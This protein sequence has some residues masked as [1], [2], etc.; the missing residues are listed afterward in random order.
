MKQSRFFAGLC[1]AVFLSV[2]ANSATLLPNGKQTFV[3]A[4][5]KPLAGGTVTLYVPGTTTLKNSYRE[6]G[7]TTLNTNPIVLDAAGRA[8]IYG[9]GT[10]R[11]VV[12]DS[13]GNLIWDQL[14]SDTS[15]AGATSWGGTST[16][17]ASAQVVTAPNFT[18]V[19]GQTIAFIAGFTNP[20]PMTVNA[21]GAPI[22]VL[23]D[24]PAGPAT[25]QGGEVVAGNVVSI[26]YSAAGGT[27]HTSIP[28]NAV[29][30]GAV[31]E[32]AGAAPPP[33]WLFAAGQCVSRTTYARLFVVIG[34]LYGACDGSTT[35]AV[36]DKRGR[37]AVGKENMNGT[38][39]GLL[40]GFFTN[41]LI[42]GGVA[43]IAG[44][45]L[46]LAQLPV[47]TPTGSVTVSYPSYTYDRFSTGA[48]N[49]SNF[50]TSGISYGQY[51]TPTAATPSF[52]PT[53]FTLTGNAIGSGAAHSLI[54]PSIIMNFIIKT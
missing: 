21:S 54:Q 32:Y 28:G 24:T 40:S 17:T 11:Q 47:F 37:V 45:A 19:D 36:P 39:A 33:G 14:T 23:I 44:E 31:Q 41:R 27:F 51:Y 29:P 2:A 12:K 50:A 9:A 22:S 53:A 34:T 16:G 48:P 42:L 25:L 52:G 3:D 46:S 43:G 35:F 5:G 8:V 38:D 4:N 10:Y 49:G 18:S 20:G 15:A 1:L 13:L 6:A 26:T 30:V 7:Q